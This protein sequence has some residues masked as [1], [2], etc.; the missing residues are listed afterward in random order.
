MAG[1]SVKTGR[2]KHQP[3]TEVLQQNQEITIISFTGI[4]ELCRNPISWQCPVWTARHATDCVLACFDGAAIMSNLLVIALFP[5]KLLRTPIEVGRFSW[6]VT[7][8]YY[9]CSLYG[10]FVRIERAV[11]NIMDIL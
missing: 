3:R 1:G 2:N 5:V 9:D 7:L 8:F 11:H 6:Q 4:L 10:G